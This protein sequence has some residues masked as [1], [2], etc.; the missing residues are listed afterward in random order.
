M[1]GF[2]GGSLEVLI[3]GWFDGGGLDGWRLVDVGLDGRRLVGVGLDGGRLYG[4]KR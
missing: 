4:S 1:G 3:G 2:R